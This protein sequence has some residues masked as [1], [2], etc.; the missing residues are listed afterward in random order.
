MELME[1]QLVVAAPP[2]KIESSGS[3]QE[4]SNWKI[5]VVGDMNSGKTSIIER[6]CD[7]HFMEYYKSTTGIDLKKKIINY[8]NKP[9]FLNICNM[10]L[11]IYIIRDTAGTEKY[12]SLIQLYY[13]GAIGLF[14]VYDITNLNSLHNLEFWMKN[15]DD[16]AP[17]NVVRIL[18][19]NKCDL[20]SNRKVSTEEGQLVAQHFG[21]PFFE[22]SSKNNLNVDDS[23][24]K[25]VSMINEMES[26]NAIKKD[27]EV[28]DDKVIL[29]EID[30]KTSSKCKC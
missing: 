27:F 4:H 22:V 25:M 3:R 30:S 24:M 8:E 17:S 26:E 10:F 15:I 20:E 21:I 16:F 12:Q 14:I 23:F 2:G 19:G 6:Y 5:I 18:I 1:D 28:L 9:I 11:F 29:G 13:R 7:G